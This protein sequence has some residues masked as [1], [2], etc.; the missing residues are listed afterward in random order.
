MHLWQLYYLEGRQKFWTLEQKCKKWGQM[1]NIL[2]GMCIYLL[3]ID[4]FQDLEHQNSSFLKKLTDIW[5]VAVVLTFGFRLKNFIQSWITPPSANFFSKKKYLI[6][7]TQV[8][9]RFFILHK[10]WQIDSGQNSVKIIHFNRKHSTKQI[11]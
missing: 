2:L 5:P 1:T 9:I 4:F 3:W 7:T 10:K 6:I 11:F 8:Q